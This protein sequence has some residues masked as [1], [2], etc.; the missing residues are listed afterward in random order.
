MIP[1]ASTTSLPF[2][3]ESKKGKEKKN[4]TTKTNL[5]LRDILLPPVLSVK[6]HRQQTVGKIKM[7]AITSGHLINDGDNSIVLK[8]T[9][10]AID[11][12]PIKMNF[13]TATDFAYPLLHTDTSVRQLYH[14]D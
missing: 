12:N 2:A 14:P 6:T 13:V 1:H 10:N 5:F 3:D 7:F 4:E 8:N 9:T 11:T